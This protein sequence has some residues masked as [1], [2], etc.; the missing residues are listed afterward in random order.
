MPTTRGTKGGVRV[1]P[2]AVDDRK[3]GSPTLA[4]EVST[5]LTNIQEQTSPML[6]EGIDR[7]AQRMTT[8]LVAAE[9]ASAPDTKILSRTSPTT[10][11]RDSLAM[12]EAAT[13]L[14]AS[15]R[16]LS[17]CSLISR[18]RTVLLPVMSIS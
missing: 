7:G 2:P 8:S 9:S 15:V 16:P 5:S 6:P 3:T 1:H 12:E 11:T 14:I 13:A 18:G 4:D 17:S 10:A